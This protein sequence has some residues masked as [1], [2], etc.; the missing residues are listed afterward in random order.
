MSVTINVAPCQNGTIQRSDVLLVL[1][2]VRK[3]HGTQGDGGPRRA[4][5]QLPL[6][7]A[8]PTTPIWG[9]ATEIFSQV[10]RAAF[11]CSNSPWKGA[12]RG[13]GPPL[14]DHVQRWP[15]RLVPLLP[16]RYGGK[17]LHQVTWRGS[18]SAANLSLCSSLLALHGVE[19]A[20]QL[21]RLLGALLC[22]PV[23]DAGSEASSVLPPAAVPL[24]GA[25][26][27]APA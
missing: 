17:L 18:T 9:P 1:S 8:Y 10:T 21:A 7:A 25:E 2:Y 19:V 11:W 24:T 23:P 5:A 22:D 15:G 3:G 13:N 16:S 12:L 26:S 27:V 6:I 4:V 14:G 20:V